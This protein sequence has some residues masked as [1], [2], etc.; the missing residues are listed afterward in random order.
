MTRRIWTDLEN[1]LVSAM[2]VALGVITTYVSV[3]LTTQSAQTWPHAAAVAG[4]LLLLAALGSAVA[5]C[6][7]HRLYPRDG[8]AWL[9]AATIMIGVQALPVLPVADGTASMT[10]QASLSSAL[11]LG[12]GFGLLL[13]ARLAEGRHHSPPPVLVGVAIGLLLLV[14]RVAW[15]HLPLSDGFSLSDG[16]FEGLAVVGAFV[17]GAGL[18]LS[19]LTTRTLRLPQGRRRIALTALLWPIPLALGAAGWTEQSGWSAIAIICGLMSCILLVSTAVDLLG[20]AARDDQSA[21]R[22]LQKQLVTL[23]ERARED[24]EQ[25][26]EVKGTIAGIAS[27]TDLIQH[28]VRLSHENRERLEELLVTETARLQRLVHAQSVDLPIDLPLDLPVRTVDLDDVIRP[29]VLARRIQGQDVSWT[30]PDLSMCD[31]VDDIAEAVNIL[32]HN[33]AQHAPG[34][35]VHVYSTRG[36]AEL[37]IADDGPGIPDEL[38]DGIFEWGFSRPGSHGQGIGLAMARRVLEEHGRTLE[39]DSHHHPG[40][41]FVIGLGP[42]RAEGGRR[43]TSAFAG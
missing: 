25:L 36:G 15:S 8:V 22:T 23:R 28:E 4:Q 32:L 19:I 3:V 1:V 41:S 20:Q 37:I 14:S 17:L 24:S 18:A 42:K 7:A 38:R 12:L 9:G 30:G 40:T 5:L 43:D 34:A 35:S 11:A 29:L 27:A 6:I 39:L 10:G 21:V 26:H 13:L 2:F 31:S 33:T 16:P